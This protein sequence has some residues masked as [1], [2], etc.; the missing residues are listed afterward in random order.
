M[1]VMVTGANGLLGFKVVEKLQQS[2]YK[3]I[4][5]HRS[6]PLQTNSIKL[7]I[8]EKKEVNELIMKTKPDVVVHAA[9]ET[10]VDLCEKEP[11]YAYRVNV[12][13]TRNVSMASQNVEAK[14]IYIST[15]YVFNGNKGNYKEADETNP[16]NAYGLTKLQGEQESAK[17]CKNHLILRT[18][19]NF[20][21]HPYKQSFVTWVIT[22]LEQGKKIKVVK[23]HFN[24]PTLT[25]KLA[26]V[27][28]EAIEKDLKGL[29]HASG[30]ERISRYEFALEIANKFN[31]PKHLIECVEMKELMNLGIWVA[32]RPR[33][34]SLNTKKIQH[35]I[36][37]KLVD[38]DAALEIIKRQKESQ[39]YAN[40]K[41]AGIVNKSEGYL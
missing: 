40:L 18:S 6:K 5:T 26:E 9:A 38:I 20:G 12:E 13:G 14:I 30:V 23:D 7:D 4:P 33:D 29:Y 37:T 3:I 32:N 8:T 24:T 21:L 39:L 31:L 2:G 25:D 34:S 15:D 17:H 27:I 41:H 35:E 10:N 16:I 22:S 36:K 28:K 1:K 19:V 11:M